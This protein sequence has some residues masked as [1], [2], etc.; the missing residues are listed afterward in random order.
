VIETADNELIMSTALPGL[1]IPSYALKHRD[2][3]AIMGAIA[4]GLSRVGHHDFMDTIWKA[5]KSRAGE[6]ERTE[7]ERLN[8][9]DDSES[10]G[11]S[12]A[13]TLPSGIVAWY[14]AEDNADDAVGNNNGTAHAI[15]YGPGKVGRAFQ[16]DGE[17]HLR[18]PGAP[19]LNSPAITVEAWVKS[20]GE[21]T[22]AQGRYRYLVAKGVYA[23]EA[24]S[25]GLY[26]GCTGGL[27]FYVY[28][29]TLDAA[30]SPGPSPGIWDG[31]WHHVAGT[32]DGAT[33]RLYVDG[34]Q[35]GNGTPAALNID[36]KLPDGNDLFIGTVWPHGARP[37]HGTRGFIGSI[38]ELSIFNRALSASE[39]QTIFSA[40]SAGKS[41]GLA[42]ATGV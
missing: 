8:T 26:T 7:V 23:D 25:Y 18:I 33:V 28:D 6:V 13:C 4:R 29:R 11:Q 12:T 9:L 5:G 14:K 3:W 30:V 36:Y 35:V 21:G 32:F 41:N 27:F 39:I 10:S 17:S 15:T 40:A 22:T 19:S 34:Q 2:W 37:A 31:K 38:D 20:P 24:A 16:F 42:P 1:W